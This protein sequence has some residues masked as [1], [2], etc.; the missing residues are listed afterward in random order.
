MTVNIKIQ[1]LHPDAVLPAYAHLASGGLSEDAGMDLYAVS[2]AILAPGK[3]QLIGTG[4]AI[5]LPVGYEAQIRP[6]SGLAAKHSITVNL[7]TIDSGYR[8][9]ISVVMFNL[10]TRD[11]YVSKADRIAQLVIARYETA[12]WSEEISLGES[13]RGVNG[14]GSSGK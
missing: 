11:Y 3:T 9:E 8:G 14:F 13:L 6:R 4:I 7:G 5:E 2:G 1:R 12:I 10:G